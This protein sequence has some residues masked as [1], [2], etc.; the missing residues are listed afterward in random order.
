MVAPP[1]SGPLL[2]DLESSLLTLS[3]DVGMIRAGAASEVG[4]RARALEHGAAA[5]GPCCRQSALRAAHQEAAGSSSILR[6]AP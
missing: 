6:P 2:A 4:D 3:A 1:T 5:H